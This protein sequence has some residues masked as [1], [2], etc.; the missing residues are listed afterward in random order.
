MACSDLPG[1]QGKDLV[2]GFE[3]SVASRDYQ[4]VPP[5]DGDDGRV[6]RD[7]ELGETHPDGGR[8]VCE[9]HLHQVRMAAL[10]LQQSDERADRH[11]FFDERSHHERHADRN[12]DPPGLIEDPWFFGLLTLAM[13]RGTANSCLERREITRLSSSSPVAAMTT[14][15]LAKPAASSEAHLAAVS[16]DEVE[17]EL[18][19]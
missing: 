14:S 6:P 18:A 3:D 15:T 19:S 2:A 11:G 9:G 4:P 10:E 16:G 12:V 1:D 7:I 17:V 13:T 8:V 5:H